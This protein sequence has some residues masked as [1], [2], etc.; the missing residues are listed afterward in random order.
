M[1]VFDC[2]REPSI[3]D[4]KVYVIVYG[5]ILFLLVQYLIPMIVSE[6][7]SNYAMV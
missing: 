3:L 6:H 5:I 1:C 2:R 4:Y 7:H